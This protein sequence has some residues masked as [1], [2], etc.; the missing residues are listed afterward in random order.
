MG[1]FLG[2]AGRLLSRSCRSKGHKV[3]PFRLRRR[4]LRV[5]GLAVR[6]VDRSQNFYA[7]GQSS[8]SLSQDA[9]N[10]CFPVSRRLVSG[11]R[12]LP[13]GPTLPGH[14]PLGNSKGGL[15]AQRG[16]VRLGSVPISSVSGVFARLGPPPGV[17]VGGSDR[18]VTATHSSC[19][20]VSGEPGETLEVVVWPPGQH[21]SAGPRGSAAH[22][23]PPVLCAGEMGHV[24][25]GVHP[26]V[27]DS[28]CPGDPSMVAPYSE[29][30]VR[31]SCLGPGPGDDD[32][33]RRFVLRVGRSP[34]RPDG[35]WHLATTREVEA[36]QL[37]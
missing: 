28:G 8:R 13:T 29:P 37:A 2:F 9:G 16:K 10:K 12:D 14:S 32:R 22:S 17:S 18:S 1:C 11:G 31:G 15:R 21:D 24:Y 3:S 35:F 26:G 4:D 23:S 30:H 5:S 20:E 34:G 25:A 36:H 6:P 27:S 7:S 33:H 19:S